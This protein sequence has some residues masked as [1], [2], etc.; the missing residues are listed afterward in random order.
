[1]AAQTRM[2]GKAFGRSLFIASAIALK[3]LMG[4]FV[5]ICSISS[6]NIRELVEKIVQKK[7]KTT[8]VETRLCTVSS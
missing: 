6:S 3:R 8:K 2:M 4:L 7:N 5:S 1:M